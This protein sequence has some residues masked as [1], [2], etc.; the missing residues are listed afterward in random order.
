[1]K[2]VKLTDAELD[3]LIAEV[4]WRV[5]WSSPWASTAKAEGVILKKLRSARLA[6]AKHKSWVEAAA[7][8]WARQKAEARAIAARR[9]RNQPR[10]GRRRKS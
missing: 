1:M 6:G 7:A 5:G 4:G 10:G 9:A 8:G 3:W 2:T